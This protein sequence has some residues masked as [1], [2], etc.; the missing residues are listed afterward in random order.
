MEITSIA[1]ATATLEY[2]HK[3]SLLCQKCG[4][5]VAVHEN[6][7]HRRCEVCKSPHAIYNKA[8]VPSVI[9]TAIVAALQRWLSEHAPVAK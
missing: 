6:Q 3:R 2:L 4:D 8:R 7:F 5:R 1:D 9:E